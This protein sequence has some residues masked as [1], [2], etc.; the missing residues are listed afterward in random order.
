MRCFI[1]IPGALVP[2][3]LAADVIGTAQRR[4]R[5]PELERLAMR[6]GVQAYGALP[7]AAARAPQL[8]WTWEQFGGTGP[9]VSAPYVAALLAQSAVPAAL[10]HCDPVHIALARDHLLVTALDDAPLR[11]AEE[12][13]LFDDAATTALGR[14]AQMHRWQGRW[15]VAF[16]PPWQL[17]AV[18]LAAALDHS[19][20]EAMPGGADAVR[21]RKLFTEIQILWHRHPVNEARE[22]TG[23]PTVNGL[24]LHGGTAGALPALDSPFVQVVADD[25][26][27]QA[28]ALA[29]QT[30]AQALR[31]LPVLAAGDVLV[32]IDSLVAAHRSQSWADWLAATAAVDATLAAIDAQV[33]ARGGQIELLLFGTHGFRR[34]MVAT[35]DRWRLWRRQALVEVLAEPLEGVG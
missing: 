1:V 21:W 3:P 34:V 6:A 12:E 15:F 17:Q 2:A 13:A 10:W 29:T 14:G 23:R 33:S 9:P 22:A 30:P 11:P 5:L 4:Q 16:D 7:P 32:Q 24:W 19:M 35:G 31:P 28:W 8:F 27:L 18:P 20:Q 25:P 26:A